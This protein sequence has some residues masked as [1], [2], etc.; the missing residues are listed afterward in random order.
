MNRRWG[1]GC[2][3]CLGSVLL[4]L[5]VVVGVGYFLVY[6][7]IQGFLAGFGTPA[8]T[9]SQT[10]S[11]QTADGQ[12]APQAALTTADVQRFV[13]VRRTVRTAMGS[14]F[15]GVQKVFTDLQNGQGPNAL[16]ILSVLRDA[17]GSVGAARTAQQAALAREGMNT[18]RYTY[19]RG[20][21]NK[22]LGV[23]DIDFQKVAQA[24]TKG[25]L[26]DLNTTVRPPSPA[27]EKLVTPFKSELT[28]T[29]PLGLLGL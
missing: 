15:D 16:T 5:L 10:Q 4:T 1:C 7:P 20:E 27:T 29:A 24:V 22:A 9:Q 6:R 19:V 21:V 23:P 2:G 28:V 18:L 3:G 25:Q 13:R 14:S 17:A 8:Q 11:A 12:T 26:P